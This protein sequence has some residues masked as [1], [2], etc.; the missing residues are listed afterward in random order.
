[1]KDSYK[2]SVEKLRIIQIVL[3]LVCIIALIFYVYHITKP[4]I[5]PPYNY[6]DECGLMP[7]GNGVTHPIG[8]EDVCK[9]ACFSLCVSKDY[10][11][12]KAVFQA[13]EGPIC[14]LCECYCKE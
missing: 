13:R 11:L 4:K 7:G 6:P 14:N 1:M 5:L 9:N 3:V 12:S 2:K 8:S 10:T